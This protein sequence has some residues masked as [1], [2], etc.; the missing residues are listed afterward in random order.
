MT[1]IDSVARHGFL[2]IS[3][4]GKTPHGLT[5]EELLA[6]Y[7]AA[8]LL[9]AAHKIP[10]ER[11]LGDWF[12]S[13]LSRFERMDQPDLAGT[14]PFTLGYT[15]GKGEAVRVVV[16]DSDEADEAFAVMFKSSP[17]GEAI[18]YSVD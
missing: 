18:P 9:A 13:H 7:R 12:P 16:H 17:L 1:T 5:D 4:L 15:N 10:V 6:R 8:K 14:Y 11:I 2:A 3:N